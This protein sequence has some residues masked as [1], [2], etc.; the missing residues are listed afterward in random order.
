MVVGNGS[1]DLETA[2]IFDVCVRGGIAVSIASVESAADSDDASSRR[3]TFARGLKV[4]AD[5]T[6][7]AARAAFETDP[8]AFDAI[9]FPGGMPGART[10]GESA[11][12]G[13]IVRLALERDTKTLIAA[14]CAAPVFVLGKLGVLRPGDRAACFPALREK[15]PEGVEFVGSAAVVES[16]TS[17]ILTSQGPGTSI[18]F[19]L[20]LVRRL[21][22]AEKAGEVADALLVDRSLVG[23]A[24]K[25]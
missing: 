21:V 17:R 23:A 10:V 22:G 24:A 3:V 7:S 5:L 9:V 1:E 2:C 25:L 16:P 6:A 15:L 12:V 8:N 18:Q 14:I 19:G 4:E 11:D 20:A 13:A